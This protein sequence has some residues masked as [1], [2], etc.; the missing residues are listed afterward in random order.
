MKLFKSLLL[1]FFMLIICSVAFC[2][3]LV[4]IGTDPIV[5][6][7]IP[8]W[9][10]GICGLVFLVLEYILGKTVWIKPN[11]ILDVVLQILLKIFSIFKK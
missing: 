9:I 8:T 3:D 5:E 7:S 2:Q 6:P 10:V 4:V 11:S 1:V